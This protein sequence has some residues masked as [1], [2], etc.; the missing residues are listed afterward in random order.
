MKFV[1]YNIQYGT[2]KDD[3]VDLVRIAN[4]IGDADVI[5]LQEV[6]R[7]NSTTGMTDQVDELA[8]LFPDHYWTYGPGV[9]L[10]GSFRDEAGVLVNRRRQFG[11]MLL[12]RTP[13]L[14]SRNHMLPKIGL[15]DQL[16]LQRTIVEGV[17]DCEL[18][19]IRVYSVHLGHASVLEREHQ[20][21]VLLN[22]LKD[23][24]DQGGL[25][26]GKQISRHWT[27]DSPEPPPMPRPAIFMG[28]FNLTPEF[29]EYELLVGRLDPKYG[30]VTPQSGLVDAWIACGHLSDAP[31]GLTCDVG[32]EGT[33]IDYAFVTTDLANHLE[34]M[35]VGTDAQGSDHQPI[36]IELSP[37]K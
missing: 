16:A 21:A 26:S 29:D 30:R 11:N 15:V 9:D 6:E 35:I 12:S 27:A 1:S 4:E 19:L 34:S 36:Y 17:I 23:A 2:G 24:P 18:G 8:Q 7:F 3:V 20:I 28:D 31:S 25:W 32:K 37:T 14:S 22:I 13:I 33:R 10:D 5:A